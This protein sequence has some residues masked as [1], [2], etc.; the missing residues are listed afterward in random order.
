MD[1]Y[2]I[3]VLENYDFNIVIV[4]F[5]IYIFLKKYLRILGLESKILY[6]VK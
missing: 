2:I 4:F 3:Y 1:I 6:I 5:D